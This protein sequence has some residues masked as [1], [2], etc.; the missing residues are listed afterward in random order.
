MMRSGLLLDFY[1][2]VNRNRSALLFKDFDSTWG[3][4]GLNPDILRDQNAL[5]CQ[6]W[7]KNVFQF[8]FIRKILKEDSSNEIQLHRKT[9]LNDEDLLYALENLALKNNQNWN[10]SSPYLS[11]KVTFDNESFRMTLIHPQI[12]NS[13]RPRV[14]FRRL[15]ANAVN[16][17]TYEVPKIL[18][19]LVN[20][21]KNVIICGGTGSGKT[22]LLQSLLDQCTSHEHLVV[23]EDTNEITLEEKNTTHLLSTENASLLD[24]CSYAL[25]ISPNRIIL[26]ELRGPEVV[27]LV[28]AM[29]TG[30]RGFLTTI[31]ANSAPECLS[32]LRTLLE[33]YA[34]KNSQSFSM[35][36]QN[37]DTIIYMED[38]KIIEI[39]SVMGLDGITPL[40]DY[41]FRSEREPV[42]EVL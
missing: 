38:K 19:E 29:N 25:R 10:T 30:H 17:S 27:P 39:I 22:T 15:R 24:F 23:L 7:F 33:F 28:L 21:K 12:T 9:S 42:N 34:P 2:E 18:A 31:H 5:I 6:D 1:Q 16:L 41:L 35:I 36:C 40:Y 14:F 26:G 4:L 20:Q 13:T 3:F 32:R 8:S 11:T 37:I